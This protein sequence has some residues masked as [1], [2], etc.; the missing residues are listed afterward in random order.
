MVPDS[1]RDNFWT[2]AFARVAIYGTFY[3][4]VN[5]SSRE[6]PVENFRKIFEG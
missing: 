2:P 3:E 4:I 5:F 1:R 6:N